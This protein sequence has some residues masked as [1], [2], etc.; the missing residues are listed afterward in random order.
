MGVV[1]EIGDDQSLGDNIGGMLMLVPLTLFAIWQ[2]VRA[3]ARL[4]AS[5]PGARTS[6]AAEAGTTS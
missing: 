2:Y 4:E 6:Q 1:L 3:P 5:V